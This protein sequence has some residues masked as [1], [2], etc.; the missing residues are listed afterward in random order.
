MRDHDASEKDIGEDTDDEEPH[1][2]TSPMDVGDDDPPSGPSSP[3]SQLTRE[4]QAFRTEMQDEFLDFRQDVYD[5]LSGLRC[6]MRTLMSYYRY[7]LP[8]PP[9]DSFS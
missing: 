7:Y 2:S 9:P 4:F 6:D 8:P 5:R 3:I 1:Y